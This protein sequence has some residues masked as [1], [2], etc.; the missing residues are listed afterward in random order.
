MRLSPEQA[1][2]LEA[3]STALADVLAT[4]PS[5]AEVTEAAI[6]GFA[7]GLDIILEP[8]SLSAAEASAADALERAA[9]TL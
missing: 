1:E 8:A 9:T 6:S 4:S 2:R 3:E 5:I 7:E